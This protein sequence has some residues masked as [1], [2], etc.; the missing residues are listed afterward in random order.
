M[1]KKNKSIMERR[2]FLE[3]FRRLNTDNPDPD[4]LNLLRQEF[5]RNLQ[6]Y[7]EE[8]NMGQLAIVTMIEQVQA[9]D[10]VKEKLIFL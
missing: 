9:N 10:L 7:Y 8:S 6:Y 1:A 3:L 5:S 4:D 2:K